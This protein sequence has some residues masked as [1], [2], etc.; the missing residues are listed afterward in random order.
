VKWAFLLLLTAAFGF[1]ACNTNANRRDLYSPLKPSGP[2]YQALQD[3]T[4]YYGVKD[5]RKAKPRATPAPGVPPAPAPVATDSTPV[6]P[7]Q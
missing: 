2:Y 6:T 4:W 1:T 5:N 3:Q 7:A